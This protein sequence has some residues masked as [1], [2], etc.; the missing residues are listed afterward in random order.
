MDVSPE[1]D[2]R[3]LTTLSSAGLL[4]PG[5]D[6]RKVIEVGRLVCALLAT[7]QGDV[8]EA[9]VLVHQS[10]EGTAREAG[11]IVGAAVGAYC[12]QYGDQV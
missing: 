3:Y 2:D 1:A 8:Y 6:E 5:G 4:N 9:A 11:A 7:G 12:P 10:G